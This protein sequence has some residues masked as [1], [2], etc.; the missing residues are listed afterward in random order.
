MVS[1]STLK[2]STG[3]IIGRVMLQNLRQGPAPSTSA[4][5]YSSLGTCL[6]PAR[7]ITI[8]APNCQTVRATSA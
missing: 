5:S 3:E 2:N 7:K 6:R 4:A 1:S 8:G